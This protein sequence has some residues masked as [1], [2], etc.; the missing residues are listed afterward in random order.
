MLSYFLKCGWKTKQ[1]DHAM[2][3]IDKK[4]MI[5]YKNFQEK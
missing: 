1:T 5:K 4:K 3:K 2:A